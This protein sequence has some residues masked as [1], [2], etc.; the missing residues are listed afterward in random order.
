MYR[1]LSLDGGGMRGLITVTLLRRL[2]A[3]VPGWL[4]RVDLMTGSSTG[5]I[6]AIGL[7]GGDRPEKLAELY[8]TYGRRIFRRTRRE[9][10]L[11]LRG[12]LRAGYDNGQL[13]AEL[14]RHLGTKRLS[15]FPRRLLVPAFALDNGNGQEAGE[16][17]GN[18][19][20]SWGPRFFHNFDASGDAE[21]YKVAL[22][23]S[24]SPGYFPAVDGFVDG[25][26]CAYHPGAAALT[27]VGAGRVGAEPPVSLAETAMLSLGTGTVDHYLP[28]DRYDWSLARW[29]PSMLYLMRDGNLRLAEYQCRLL[30]GERYCRL[31]PRLQRTIASDQWAC[32]DELEQIGQEADIS[33]TVA[34]LQ[35]VWQGEKEA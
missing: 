29:L 32:W 35:A 34:W 9:R 3:A 21:A 8:T 18:G 31:S 24:A 23:T 10:W 6:L 4:D 17:R 16:H 33:A 30:L 27:W 15:D 13:E 25:G 11:A 14:R 2:E 28:G 7:A 12:I 20:R 5:G 26:V 19:R 1:I 22:Y